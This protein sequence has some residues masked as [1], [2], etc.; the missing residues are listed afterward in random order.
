MYWPPEGLFTTVKGL[1][2]AGVCCPWAD[3]AARPRMVTA[4]V[5]L[6]DFMRRPMQSHASE[7]TLTSF[8]R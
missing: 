8:H 1:F 5:D 7:K 4:K 2:D 3:S 6:I